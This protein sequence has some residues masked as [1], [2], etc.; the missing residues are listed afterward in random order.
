[1]YRVGGKN[2]SFSLLRF[3]PYSCLSA[4]ALLPLS[5]PHLLLLLLSL[6]PQLLV[7]LLLLWCTACAM[8]YASI[9]A[10]KAIAIAVTSQLMF[11]L[12]RPR[13]HFALMACT[14]ILSIRLNKKCARKRYIKSR[15]NCD[16]KINMS[17]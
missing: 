4:L 12:R 9:A 5:S 17:S 14:C 8:A 13:L 3:V 11:R 15:V 10:I 7:P 1:M 6:L 16:K 2:F